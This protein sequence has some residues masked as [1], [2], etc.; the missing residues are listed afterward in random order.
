MTVDR[1]F[2]FVSV[3]P[4]IASSASS[5]RPVVR[6]EE[7]EEEVTAAVVSSME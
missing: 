4:P 3:R 1:L 6:N 2:R 5:T 7:V